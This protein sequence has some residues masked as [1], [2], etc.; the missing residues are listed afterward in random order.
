MKNA[1][2]FLNHYSLILI[3]G[4]KLYL[5]NRVNVGQ[6]KSVLYVNGRQYSAVVINPY[7][8][9]KDILNF[10]LINP[11]E[12]RAQLDIPTP[13]GEPPP[14]P[15]IPPIPPGREWPP[16][17]VPPPKEN[18]P[19]QVPDE[20]EDSEFYSRNIALMTILN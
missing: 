19:P 16:R 9:I 11:A 4:V 8:N 18:P 6:G 1:D 15:F 2:K 13:V 5:D 20:P 12:Y 10:L 3:L 17:I 7:Y 14:F